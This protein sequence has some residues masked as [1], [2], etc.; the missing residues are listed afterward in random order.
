M[1]ASEAANRKY[2]SRFCSSSASN[3]V[4]NRRMT[5]V[6]FQVIAE[7]LQVTEP[8]KSAA[9]HVL[10]QKLPSDEAA[11]KA[12]C[13]AT[14]ANNAVTRFRDADKIIRKAYAYGRRTE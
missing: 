4:S 12:G 9:H 8:T 1:I 5:E 13:S 6:Q 2:C 10:V 7:L 14:A 3:S 11:K